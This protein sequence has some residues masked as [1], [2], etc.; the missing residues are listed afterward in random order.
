VTEAIVLACTLLLALAA[1]LT[2]VVIV[3]RSLG[4]SSRVVGTVEHIDPQP[5]FD[6]EEQ[7]WRT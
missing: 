1:A 6:H 4:R 2:A 5:L 7:E 3:F